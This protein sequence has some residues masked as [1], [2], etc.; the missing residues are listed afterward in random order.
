MNWGL[1]VY[2]M[3]IE[4][5]GTALF[6]FL[7]QSAIQANS[8]FG[9]YTSLAVIV[10]FMVS[11]GIVTIKGTVERRP[12]TLG[13]AKGLVGMS[14][15]LSLVFLVG[16]LWSE[17]I[18]EDTVVACPYESNLGHL[19]RCELLPEHSLLPIVYGMGLASTIIILGSSARIA[20]KLTGKSTRTSTPQT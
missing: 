12:V 16:V 11:G 20:L 5:F 9:V 19:S 2:A 7:E 14:S 1:L 10:S 13:Q 4:A 3:T 8:E 15:I 18:R 6:P 17:A